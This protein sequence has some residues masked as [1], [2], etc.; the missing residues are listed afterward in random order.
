MVY[1]L[2]KI[3][4]KLIIKVV[5]AVCLIKIVGGGYFNCSSPLA[6]G[7]VANDQHWKQNR[8]ITSTRIHKSHH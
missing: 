3:S 1:L 8:P 6:G 5:I 2:F 7:G 4:F